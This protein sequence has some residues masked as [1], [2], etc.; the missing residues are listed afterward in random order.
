MKEDQGYYVA[1]SKE[2][3]NN[4]EILY[5]EYWKPGVRRIWAKTK[6]SNGI[7]II[8][9]KKEYTENLVEIGVPNG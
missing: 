9:S 4:F 7:Y 8:Y 5:I 1:E 2:D 3:F 6:N